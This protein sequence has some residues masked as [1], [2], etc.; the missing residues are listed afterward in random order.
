MADAQ[1][2]QEW[3]ASGKPISLASTQPTEWDA[4]GKPI[5]GGAPDLTSNPNS[6][7]TYKMNGPHGQVGVPFSNVF[8]AQRTGYKL[9][10]SD[11]DRY[12]KDYTNAPVDNGPSGLTLGGTLSSAL[13]NAGSAILGAGKLA[14]RAAYDPVGAG[15]EMGKG[16]A[17]AEK[18]AGPQTAQYARDTMDPKQSGVIPTALNAA[19]TAT[20]ALSMVN[21]LNPAGS[22]G[23]N[24]AIDAGN[25]DEALGQGI[26]QG[27]AFAAPSIIGKVAGKARSILTG[28]TKAAAEL[29]A[30]TLADNAKIGEANQT[31]TDDFNQKTADAQHATEGREL[32][33]K[34]AVNT[35]AD[36]IAA[37]DAADQSKLADGY[38][39]QL[40]NTKA[41]NQQ[42]LDKHNAVATRLGQQNEAT[43]QT[44]GLRQQQQAD[45][46]D[47]T[48]KYFAQED[49]AK[50]NAKGQENAAWQPWRQKM[51]G[52]M[53]DGQEIADPLQKIS[54]TS[55]DVARALRQLQPPPS[56]APIDSNYAQ[57]RAAIM[58]SLGYKGDYFDLPET[59]RTTVDKIATSNGFEPDP[60]DFDPQPG[61][62][63]PVELVHRANSI[64]QSYIRN[65]RYEGPILGEMKQ[66][67]KVLR[68]SVSRAS[69]EAGA[70]P[71]L[72]AA[73]E[74]TV[75]Y[76]DAFGRDRYQPQTQDDI[77]E[78]QA[79]PE[80][81]KE[82]DDEERLA[83]AAQ[84]D[85]TLV[86]SFRGVKAARENLK[87]LPSEDALRKGLKQVPSPPTVGDLRPGY[88]LLGEPS[89]PPAP[90]PAN[91]PTAR[92]AQQ[93]QPPERVGLP[94][95]PQLTP[96]KTVGPEDIQA[97]KTDALLK[98]TQKIRNISLRAGTGATSLSALYSIVQAFKGNLGGLADVPLEMAGGA[99]VTGTGYGIA[100]LIESPNVLKLLTKPTPAD[101]A[102]ISPEV[103]R[104]LQ[105]IIEQAKAKGIKVSPA[106]AAAISAHA[107]KTNWYDRPSQ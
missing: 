97:A 11:H 67:A 101:V 55:P 40:A 65:G 81:Y 28:G 79:N 32:S 21:P 59:A 62:P 85:P 77:R 34:Q 36:D 105:P 92:A 27:A 75:K 13:H 1:V 56:E 84:F 102:A 2:A 89:G 33:H 15:V 104:G 96:T 58:K 37:Q 42:V 87:K 18:V 86:D 61:K 46:D 54:T 4:D 83:K 100:K 44:L 16:I 20:S 23:M 39:Q 22:A 93:V 47:M 12:I 63:I 19:R 51:Q 10:P 68:A 70:L 69:T 24:A 106:I 31:A 80:A 82:R 103:A 6:E 57:D 107:T 90:A 48:Q 73:R 3:D 60:I 74:A 49:A 8:Q 30:S 72:T 9:D 25:P 71:D 45:L 99:T 53:I 5:V 35:K 64:L 26:V 43:N 76:Q 66:V 29:N 52:V 17:A 95:P 7:G 91:N 78:Q 50:A 41:H 38:D 98:N 14:L 94:T 88:S